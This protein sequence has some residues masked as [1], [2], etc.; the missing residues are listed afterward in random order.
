MSILR[1]CKS[2]RPGLSACAWGRRTAAAK[3]A[4]VVGICNTARTGVLAAR[5]TGWREGCQ[6]TH[7]LARWQST[8]LIDTF[9][10]F[11]TAWHMRRLHA[12]TATTADAENIVH[13]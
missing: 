1:R 13:L 3:P 7:Q 11:S 2:W 9:D 6:E 12:R 8:Q 5:Q 4:A 10:V